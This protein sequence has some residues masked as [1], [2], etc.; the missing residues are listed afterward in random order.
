MVRTKWSRSSASISESLCHPARSWWRRLTAAGSLRSDKTSSVGTL[1]LWYSGCD[2]SILSP[3]GLSRP[4]PDKRPV[5]LAVPGIHPS[6]KLITVKPDGRS[7][8]RR[9]EKTGLHG[10]PDR[11]AVYV[12]VGGCAFIV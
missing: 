2:P 1:S 7:W 3:F 4:L 5:L 9:P 10:S 6:I 12:A 11:G 8:T